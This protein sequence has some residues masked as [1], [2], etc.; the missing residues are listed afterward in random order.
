MT[1][2]EVVAELRL[3]ISGYPYP[4]APAHKAITE[5]IRCVELQIPKV[6]KIERW[7]PAYCPNCDEEL[8]ESLGDGFYRHHIS[9]SICECGQKLKWDKGAGE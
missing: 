8:S 5:A 9:L 2:D 4:D 6:P 1:H 3:I 7:T